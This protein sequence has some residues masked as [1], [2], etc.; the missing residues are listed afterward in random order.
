M[1]Q[2]VLGDDEALKQM[3][4]PSPEQEQFFEKEVRP[5]LIAKC[6]G[7]HGEKDQKGEVRLDSAEEVIRESPGGF[8]VVPG[9]PEESRLVGVIDYGVFGH[10]AAGAGGEDADFPLESQPVLTLVARD[11]G[12]PVQVHQ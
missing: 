10:G 3:R 5:L 4:S 6:V 11:F 7:C 9:K 12:N 2:G 8:V 1:A